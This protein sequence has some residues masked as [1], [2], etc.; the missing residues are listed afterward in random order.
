MP[1]LTPLVIVSFIRNK[2]YMTDIHL[3]TSS[4][5]DFHFSTFRACFFI[6]VWWFSLTY[7]FIASFCAEYQT[8][9]YQTWAVQP[10]QTKISV[11]LCC[12]RIVRGGRHCTESSL[13]TSVT[14]CL[15]YRGLCPRWVKTDHSKSKQKKPWNLLT[16]RHIQDFV[17]NFQVDSLF[18]NYVHRCFTWKMTVMLLS[19]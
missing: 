10:Q 16:A 2:L 4:S 5:P 1:Q 13:T 11:F 12:E 18:T 15:I 8:T 17:P 9:L 7:L 19:I 14:L 6:W 3:F